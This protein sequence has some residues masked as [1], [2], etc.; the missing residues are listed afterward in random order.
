MIDVEAAV[1]RVRERTPVLPPE[2]VAL[3]EAAGRVLAEDVAADA[4]LPRFD[5]AAM[6]GYAVRSVDA[7]QA[8]VALRV[9]GRIRAGEEAKR[10]LEAGEA[11]EIM[12]GAPVPPGADSVQQVEKTRALDAGAR[13]ELQHP[14]APGQNVA[15]RGSEVKA[16]ER[17]LERGR[18]LDPAALGVLAAV[19]RA[20]LR[21]GTRPAVA[22]LVTGD[23]LVEAGETPGPGRIRDSNG[24]ALVAMARAA[25][26]TVVALGREADDA[27][28]LVSTLRRGLEHDVLVVSGGV[29]AGVFDLVEK[30]LAELGVEVCFERVAIKPGAPLVFG[31]RGRTLVF[32]LP[33]N[34]VSAQVTFE[35]FVRPALLRLQGATQA[36]RRRVEVELLE[37]VRNTSGRRSHLPAEVA[38]QGGRLVARPVR[39]AGSA[40]LVAHARANALVILGPERRSAE[41]G[42]RA[43]ALLLGRFVEDS[44]AA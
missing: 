7:A 6:D 11:V 37:H 8:P 33:G 9:V 23:E 44:G 17:V 20:A 35:I 10:R 30:A 38:W 34:P 13:V 40:D 12:T 42:E 16:G 29:S 39:S 5:R 24:P 36:E 22:I 2:T 21:V 28:R 14:V 26:A 1:A 18:I 41:A 19:G 31:T 43:P 4:D 3:A 15:R 27:P 32:G 25:G